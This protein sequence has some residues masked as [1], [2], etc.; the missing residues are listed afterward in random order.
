MS[1]LV[2]ETPNFYKEVENIN[3]KQFVI[4]AFKTIWEKQVSGS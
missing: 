1:A 2:N 4:D 3:M